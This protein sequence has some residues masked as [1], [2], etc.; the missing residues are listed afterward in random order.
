MIGILGDGGYRSS[1]RQ[2]D[3]YTDCGIVYEEKPDETV[4]ALAMQITV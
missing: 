1:C 4:S 2:T 3:R